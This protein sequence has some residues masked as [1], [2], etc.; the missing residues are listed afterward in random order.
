MNE[1][2]A[3]TYDHL[4]A[5]TARKGVEPSDIERVLAGLRRGAVS[6][7]DPSDDQ[8]PTYPVEGLTARPWWSVDDLPWARGVRDQAEKVCAEFRAVADTLPSSRALDEDG[9]WAEEGALRA[10]G[11][12]NTLQLVHRGRRR[13]LADRFP[14]AMEALAA[15]PGGDS[16]G[17]A[18]FSILRA[19]SAILPHTGYTSAHLRCHL[20][21]AEVPGA[22][23][24]VGHEWRDWRAEELLV[25]DDTYEHEAVNEG[26]QDRV[27]L[28]FDVWHPDLSTLER[29]AFQESMD[30]L[31]RRSTRAALLQSLSG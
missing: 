15:S 23:L 2:L 18:F 30:F 19:G 9:R 1:D 4:L 6:P 25:F 8:D 28:L 3:A 5:W 29:A 10:S 22:R 12:W 20:V 24:R 16:C 11:R 13:P 31:R 21:V 14:R 17:M 27:V 7:R 26:E